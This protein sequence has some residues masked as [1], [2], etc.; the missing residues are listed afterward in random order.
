MPKPAFK[1]LK[2][3][4]PNAP[5]GKIT[6]PR[7]GLEWPDEW[8]VTG[9][10]AKKIDG[11]EQQ[12]ISAETTR[13]L[14]RHEFDNQGRIIRTEVID[15]KPAAETKDIPYDWFEPIEATPE[16]AQAPAAQAAPVAPKTPPPNGPKQP[17][18][19]A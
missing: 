14:A 1:D 10:Q 2:V 13:R 9:K 3:T 11:V 16:P 19:T 17:T 4:G 18:S 12:L 15:G 5:V 7:K 6:D 8:R